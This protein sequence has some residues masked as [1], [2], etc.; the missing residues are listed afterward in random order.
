MLFTSLCLL[1]AVRKPKSLRLV[2]NFSESKLKTADEK[3]TV[4]LWGIRWDSSLNAF[5]LA[6]HANNNV[7]SCSLS[8]LEGCRILYKETSKV[9]W[10]SSALILRIQRGERLLLAETGR[11]DIKSK[12][13]R[14]I[15]ATRKTSTDLFTELYNIP[16]TDDTE[17]CRIYSPFAH[18]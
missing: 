6:D 12:E 10:V 9:W 5:L 7:K 11:W 13:K 4:M 15:V 16:F 3:A 17:V 1:V 8:I 14:L 2:G 18:Q